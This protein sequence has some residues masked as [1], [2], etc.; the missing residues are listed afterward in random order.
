M[1]NSPYAP[2]RD[3]SWAPHGGLSNVPYTPPRPDWAPHG[4]VSNAPQGK[5]S[6]HGDDL[7][8]TPGDLFK[9]HDDHRSPPRDTDAEEH[10]GDHYH[11]M[12]SS[13]YETSSHSS[14]NSLKWLWIALSIVA[15]VG[16][17]VGL[18]F[19]F[20]RR[21]RRSNNS[22][23]DMQLKSVACDNPKECNMIQEGIVVKEFDNPKEEE[24]QVSL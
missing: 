9:D 22:T 5:S 8:N 10:Y 20:V 24:F 14:T 18:V 16:A 12:H 17:I 7:L 11:Y 3:G 15:G 4:G 13:D 1:S 23:T 21:Q 2:Q 19:L 6:A